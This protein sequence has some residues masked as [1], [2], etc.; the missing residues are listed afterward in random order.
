MTMAGENESKMK[1]FISWSGEESHAFAGIIH[2]WLPTVLHFVDPWMSSKDIA[3]GKRWDPEIGDILRK[4]SYCIV[5][6]T[7]SVAR[8]PWV[9]FEAGAVS[10]IVEQSYVSP[11]LLGVSIEDLG[12]L[13]LSMFQCTQFNKDEVAELL[14]SIN[15]EAKSP[16]SARRLKTSLD[17]SWARLREKVEDIALSGIDT[18]EDSDDEQEAENEWLDDDAEQ[19]LLAVAESGE[20]WPSAAEIATHLGENTV[21]TQYHIDALVVRGFLRQPIVLG[22]PVK[23]MVTPEGRAYV[24]EHEL[25]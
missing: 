12:G 19:V 5:C 8:E 18:P 2:D 17:Y 15:S 6:V 25:I 9:N 14:R 4:A 10:K 7:P 3:K 21:R 24:V 20:Y 11:L 23:Y 16:I 13:P 22:G 1:V